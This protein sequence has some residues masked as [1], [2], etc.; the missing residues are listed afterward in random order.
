MG[1]HSPAERP[2]NIATYIRAVGVLPSTQYLP[3][4]S[5]Q[6][7]YLRGN[8]CDGEQNSRGPVTDRTVQR[9]CSRHPRLAD[10]LIPRAA[11]RMPDWSG[12]NFPPYHNLGY[13]FAGYWIPMDP[14][15]FANDSALL[16]SRCSAPRPR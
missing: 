12:R 6:K 2:P 9:P 4:Q 8:E 5:Q 11:Q 7:L 16:P 1:G 15:D 3:T 13:W 10:L 14:L